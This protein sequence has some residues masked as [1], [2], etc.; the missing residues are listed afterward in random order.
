MA[1]PG[2]PEFKPFLELENA[3]RWGYFCN[4]RLPS[5]TGLSRGW[6]LKRS[7]PL[8]TNRGPKNFSVSQYLFETV[9]TCFYPVS[10][11]DL[12]SFLH[13]F[14]KLILQPLFVYNTFKKNCRGVIEMLSIPLRPWN[15][16]VRNGPLVHHRFCWRIA[17]WL[18][19]FWVAQLVHGRWGM[20]SSSLIRVD[21]VWLAFFQYSHGF[22]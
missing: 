19:S 17:I 20:G 7:E 11:F 18:P 4:S 6:F 13:H 14:C 10:W 1:V 2:F 21:L 8:N 5:R 15:S 3:E 16:A 12:L 9:F 22:W